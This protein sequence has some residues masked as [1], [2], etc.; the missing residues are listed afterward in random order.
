MSDLLVAVASCDRWQDFEF[1]TVNWAGGETMIWQTHQ[2]F[3]LHCRSGNQQSEPRTA[4]YWSHSSVL[5]RSSNFDF[6]LF[7]KAKATKAIVANTQTA[8]YSSRVIFIMR[9]PTLLQ[10][11]SATQ[12]SIPSHF[13]ALDGTVAPGRSEQETCLICRSERGLSWRQKTEDWRRKQVAQKPVLSS[14]D[15][16]SCGVPMVWQ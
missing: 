13:Q 6:L 16:P 12:F 5:S 10:S 15:G 8:A 1:W 9:A 11:E 7:A 2:H 3:W 4:T 14:H